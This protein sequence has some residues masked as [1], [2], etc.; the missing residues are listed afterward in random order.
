MLECPLPCT[1]FSTEVKEA[2]RLDDKVALGLNF[3]QT[4]QVGKTEKDLNLEKA[5]VVNMKIL[6]YMHI[7]A[8]HR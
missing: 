8:S 1:T 3:H 6:D 4:V 5:H 2:G 7:T